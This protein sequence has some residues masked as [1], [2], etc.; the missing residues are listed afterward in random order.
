[1]AERSPADVAKAWKVAEA[2]IARERKKHEKRGLAFA[3][4]S[5]EEYEKKLK[6]VE[7]PIILWHGW[8]VSTQPGGSILCMAGVQNPDTFFWH[9]LALAISFGNRN[10]IARHDEFLTGF[11]SRFPT[12]AK[13]APHGFSLAPFAT[14]S[15]MFQIGIPVGIEKTGYFGNWVL[16]QMNWLDV[17]KYL[18]RGAFFF[19]VI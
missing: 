1:M 18:D 10:P 4:L 8:T 17:G 13:P 7:S 19:D 12:C 5:R 14:T 11:D 15:Y 3:G 6:R 16:Q 9:S 2:E